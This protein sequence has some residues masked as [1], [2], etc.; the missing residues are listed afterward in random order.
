[1]NKL[2]WIKTKDAKPKDSQACI[3][4]ARNGLVE[5]YWNEEE[6]AFFQEDV[7]ED[8][9]EAYRWFPAQDLRAIL[10]ENEVAR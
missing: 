8:P 9:F 10:S 6:D 3:V 5:A 2:K 1:M 4:E 7:W